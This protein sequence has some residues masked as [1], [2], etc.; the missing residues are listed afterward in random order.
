MQ[1]PHFV[2]IPSDYDLL[3][4]EERGRTV[5]ICVPT[6]DPDGIPIPAVWFEEGVSPVWAQLV[7]IAEWV[8]GDPWCVSEL[9]ERIVCSLARRHGGDVGFRPSRRVLREALWVARDLRAGGSR[10]ERRHRHF[11]VRLDDIQDTLPDPVDYS[12]RYDRELFLKT[13]GREMELQGDARYRQVAALLMAGLTWREVADELGFVSSGALRQR[14]YR[15]A[16][17]AADVVRTKV[18]DA[19]RYGIEPIR[20]KEPGRSCSFGASEIPSVVEGAA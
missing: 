20:R 9:V 2:I 6:H 1:S 13:L 11:E 15:A 14:Y 8:L 4:A 10:A 12:E 16:R 5:P 17:R 19:E 18:S 7:K 3:P